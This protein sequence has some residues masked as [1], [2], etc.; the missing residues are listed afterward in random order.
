[1]SELTVNDWLNL[2]PCPPPWNPDLL[3]R[4]PPTVN[5]TEGEIER[6]AEKCH[7]PPKDRLSTSVPNTSSVVLPVLVSL[8]SVILPGTLIAVWVY[9]RK[10]WSTDDSCLQP[11]DSQS[12][13]L[14]EVQGPGI[15]CFDN[16]TYKELKTSSRDSD[17]TNTQQ[18]VADPDK[19]KDVLQ[20]SE[21][22][23]N[24]AGPPDI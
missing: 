5:L 15:Q 14:K 18:D 7:V 4:T 8:F 1:M 11:K 9:R 2:A 24:K 17:N 13:L 19:R 6:I 3:Y 20:N 12:D 16:E 23:R 21:K 10:K 22:S